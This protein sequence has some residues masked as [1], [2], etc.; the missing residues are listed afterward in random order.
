MLAHV[1]TQDLDP[2]LCACRASALHYG[3]SL[4]I[5]DFLTW[6][7]VDREVCKQKNMSVVTAWKLEGI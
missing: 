4:A 6:G 1:G 7:C 2:E 5:I 3:T